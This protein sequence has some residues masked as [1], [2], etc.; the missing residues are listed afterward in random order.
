MKT[1]VTTNQIIYTLLYNQPWN[2]PITGSFTPGQKKMLIFFSGSG[3]THIAGTISAELHFNGLKVAELR[4]FT[5]EVGSHKAF[6]PVNFLFQNPND[7][8]VNFEI[9]LTGNTLADFNDYF[10]LTVTVFE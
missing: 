3:W 7:D 5:N 2:A 8:V 6:V 9:I 10:N 4:C 1:L